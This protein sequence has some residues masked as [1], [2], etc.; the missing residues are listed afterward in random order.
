MTVIS[1]VQSNIVRF[2]SSLYKG[3]VSQKNKA[4][5]LLA[6]VLIGCIIIASLLYILQVNSIAS[7][8]FKIRDLKK[9]INELENR[10][11]TLQ[12]NIS[13]LKSIGNLQ[14][15]TETFNMVKAQSIEYVTLPPVSVVVA[16]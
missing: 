7:Q 16:K 10:N 8:G 14:S 11:K 4:R 3:E 1:L 5:K 9:Q 2:H 6:M 13:N 15:K 12:V